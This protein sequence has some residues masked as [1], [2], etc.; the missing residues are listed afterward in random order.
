[1]QKKKYSMSKKMRGLLLDGMRLPCK[2]ASL[3]GL[4]KGAQCRPPSGTRGTRAAAPPLCSAS[5]RTIHVRRDASRRI[6][7]RDAAH[8][9]TRPGAPWDASRGPGKMDYTCCV[10]CLPHV[11]VKPRGRGHIYNAPMFKSQRSRGLT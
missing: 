3:D 11:A 6:R 8:Q 5:R 9:G 1:M 4:K 7:G 2:H 10:V